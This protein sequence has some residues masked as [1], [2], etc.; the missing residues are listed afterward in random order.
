MLLEDPTQIL[1][2]LSW[3]N[4]TQVIAGFSCHWAYATNNMRL[5]C[6]IHVLASGGDITSGAKHNPWTGSELTLVEI[7]GG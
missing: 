5:S 3:Q 2:T 7:G 1:F 4:Q 6:T